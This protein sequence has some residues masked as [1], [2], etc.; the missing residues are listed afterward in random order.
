MPQTQQQAMQRKP[1]LMPAD[2]ILKVE[3]LAETKKVSFAEVVRQAVDAFEAELSADDSDMLEAMVEAYL[4]T[5]KAAI[6]KIDQVMERLDETHD[7]LGRN[8]YES[9]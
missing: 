2:M 4:Q 1:I 5:A 7:I 6:T 8:K 3:R 9:R